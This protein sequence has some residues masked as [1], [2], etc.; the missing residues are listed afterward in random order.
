M[1]K[2]G[3]LRWLSD[4]GVNKA[5]LAFQFGH[6]SKR[7]RRWASC[8]KQTTAGHTEKPEGPH[9]IA[10]GWEQAAPSFVHPAD[11]HLLGA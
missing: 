10:D 1:D 8:D 7:A 11:R 9:A 2:G 5:C 4:H 6:V 3:A